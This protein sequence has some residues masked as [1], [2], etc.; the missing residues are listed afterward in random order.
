MQYNKTEKL[1]LSAYGR[2]GTYI[3]YCGNEVLHHHFVG[4]VCGMRAQFATVCNT[5]STF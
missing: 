4:K 2:D 3:K 1:Q 5:C